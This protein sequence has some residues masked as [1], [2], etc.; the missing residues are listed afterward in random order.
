[1]VPHG[2][3]TGPVPC[4]SD[5]T[6]LYGGDFGAYSPRGWENVQ[7]RGD[8]SCN[9]LVPPSS[10]SIC[11][12][13]LRA[14]PKNR[15]GPGRDLSTSP[16]A[17]IAVLSRSVTYSNSNGAVPDCQLPILLNIRQRALGRSPS[18]IYLRLVSISLIQSPHVGK[19]PTQ[20][21]LVLLQ[22]ANTDRES[23]IRSKSPS[24]S[25]ALTPLLMRNPGLFELKAITTP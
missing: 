23:G 24:A 21:H 6:W 5:F 18:S 3:E 19:H 2:P 14:P 16:E 17:L 1:M 12:C 10:R 25:L 15:P 8:G 9:L 11:T 7:R 22:A 20:I 13:Q 4:C